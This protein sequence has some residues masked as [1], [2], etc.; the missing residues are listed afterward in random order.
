MVQIHDRMLLNWFVPSQL[1]LPPSTLS[2]SLNEAVVTV[3]C[4]KMRTGFEHLFTG[5][6]Y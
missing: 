3:I 4:P 2:T 1:E 6:N 5:L